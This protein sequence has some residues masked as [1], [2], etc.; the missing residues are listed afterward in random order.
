MASNPR[1]ISELVV[2]ISFPKELALDEKSRAILEN[3]ALTCPVQQ[4]LHPDINVQTSFVY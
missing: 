2:K 1:R 3:I 4:S